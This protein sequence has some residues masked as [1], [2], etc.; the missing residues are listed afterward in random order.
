MRTFPLSWLFAVLISTVNFQFDVFAKVRCTRINAQLGEYA[1][2]NLLPLASIL[3]AEPHHINGLLSAS[4][5]FG[6]YR[7][8]C[9]PSPQLI[10]K[11]NPLQV[12]AAIKRAIVQFTGAHFERK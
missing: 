1:V 3:D 6:L 4:C 12:L 7:A 9:L 10:R 8:I 2:Q 5:E 11:L